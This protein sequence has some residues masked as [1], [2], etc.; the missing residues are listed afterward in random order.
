MGAD[1]EALAG[2]HVVV[3]EDDDNA[4]LLLRDLFQYFGANVT[5]ADS[6]RG[7][8]VRLRQVSPDVVVADM[9]LGGRNADWLLQEARKIGCK[10]PF[11]AVTAYDFDEQAL[12]AQGFA[13]F[14]RKP[15]QRDRLVDTVVAAARRPLR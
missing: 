1:R 14:L 9:R 10:A 15:L 6:A 8:L 12:L 13:A 2:L 11:V 7:A 3:V 5:A 4:R